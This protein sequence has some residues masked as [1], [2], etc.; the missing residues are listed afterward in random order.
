MNTFVLS[1]L[2]IEK[3]VQ[4]VI[5]N[6]ELMS[7]YGLGVRIVLEGGIPCSTFVNHAGLQAITLLVRD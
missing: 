6:L 5:A 3:A 2:V 4:A 7:L 1:H